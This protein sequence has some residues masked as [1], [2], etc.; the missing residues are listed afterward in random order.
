M[1]RGGESRIAPRNQEETY[2]MTADG[3]S[4]GTPATPEEAASRIES[5]NEER[6]KSF[7]VSEYVRGCDHYTAEKFQTIGTPT[8]RT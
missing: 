3:Q 6:V 2:V 7:P 5:R 1:R 4:I 8:L